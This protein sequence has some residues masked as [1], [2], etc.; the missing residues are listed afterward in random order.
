MFHQWFQ[1]EEKWDFYFQN[2]FNSQFHSIA[3][4]HAL[5]FSD[6][7]TH[8]LPTNFCWRFL[9]RNSL[10]GET[11]HFCGETHPAAK[12]TTFATKLTF[13]AAKLTF[14]ETHHF[15][16]ETHFYTIYF[17]MKLFSSKSIINLDKAVENRR[18]IFIAT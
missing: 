2:N 8:L 4:N 15:C 6:N 18:V 10:C 12:L 17:Q 9:R 7:I 14:D 16:G 13:S 1:A 3:N 5:A 11:H